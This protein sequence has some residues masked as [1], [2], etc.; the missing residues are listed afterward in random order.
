MP[1]PSEL[2]LCLGIYFTGIIAANNERLRIKLSAFRTTSVNER[3][4]INT[5]H[6]MNMFYRANVAGLTNMPYDVA[7]LNNIAS[8]Q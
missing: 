8:R 6:K 3:S 5:G 4:R 1:R 7:T 2:S